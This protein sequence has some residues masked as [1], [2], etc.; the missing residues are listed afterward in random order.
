M[1]TMKELRT[2]IEQEQRYRKKIDE[3]E[4]KLDACRQRLLFNIKSI[5]EL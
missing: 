2:S 4:E 3:Y 1:P 5:F